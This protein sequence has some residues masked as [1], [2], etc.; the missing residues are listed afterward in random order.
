MN[1]A[2]KKLTKILMAGTLMT[3]YQGAGCNFNLDQEA[4]D[5]L[6]G[7]LGEFS[8]FELKFEA[9]DGSAFGNGNDGY[10][11]GNGGHDDDLFDDDDSFDDDDL[12]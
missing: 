5:S 3:V 4:L 6:L 9:G 11:H 10:H 2:G 12:L 1:R 7:T 8:D